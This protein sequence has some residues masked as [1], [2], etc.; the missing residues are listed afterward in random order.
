M[1][2]V[3]FARLVA[4]PANPPPR[5]RIASVKALRP[6]L[7]P[8]VRITRVSSAFTAPK[9]RVAVASVRGAPNRSPRL[10]VTSLAA[11]PTTPADPYEV[12]IYT[13]NGWVAPL[14]WVS[15]G[16]GVWIDAGIT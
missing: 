15:A 5:V 13:A 3:V 2:G 12:R 9:A 10:L 14:I 8:R 4:G 7:V 6:E 16:P 1:V 11:A